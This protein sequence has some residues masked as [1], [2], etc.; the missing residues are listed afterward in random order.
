M[1]RL[2]DCGS[3]SFV[4]CARCGLIQQNPQPEARAVEARYD[5]SYLRYEEERQYAYRDLE[6]RALSD[7]GLTEAARPLFARAAEA[8]RRPRALDVGCA[9]GALLASLREQG[10]EPQGVEVS[11]EL[12]RYGAERHGLPIAAS[13][14]EEAAFP[15][16][17][18]DLVH[19]S[20]L[21]EHLNDPA[22]FL[23]E[24]ARL[25]AP[26]GIVVLTTPNA[27]GFQARLLGAQWRSAIYDHLYLFS[28]RTLGL[29][30]E[31]KGFR[32]GREITWGGWAAGLRPAFVK[33]PLDF[34]AKR[35]G[36]G[37]VMAVLCGRAL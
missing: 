16:S 25:L 28:R 26:G 23:G 2:W 24:V 14:L 30:L 8:G 18:F 11:A 36:T 6:L 1:R 37:D 15:S 27:D 35:W 3:F 21:V 13:T 31:E 32:I 22:A 9:T 17:S 12:A 34:L 33:K 19:A 7:L 4:R 5:G 29:L 20:H 10:W